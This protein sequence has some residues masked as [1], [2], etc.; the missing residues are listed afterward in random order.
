MDN[1]LPGT[2]SYD[3]L[4][5]RWNGNL[6]QVHSLI[7]LIE[8]MLKDK[9]VYY[10]LDF[11]TFPS[12]VVPQQ[13]L[14][15]EQQDRIRYDE[16][17]ARH[18][19]LVQE[20]A[21][22]E[23]N[24]GAEFRRLRQIRDVEHQ[25]LSRHNEE[26]FWWMKDRRPKE[27]KF[28]LPRTLCE[29]HHKKEISEYPKDVKK[30]LDDC[31]SIIKIYE[32]VLS[33]TIFNDYRIKLWA[34]RLCTD[35]DRQ[36]AV[37]PLLHLMDIRATPNTNVLKEI[38]ADFVNISSI[39]NFKSALAACAILTKVQEELSHIDVA[40]M[41]SDD[42]L[43][44]C[45]VKQ[46]NQRDMGLQ[47][48]MIKYSLG[49]GILAPASVQVT[50]YT[51]RAAANAARAANPIA[52]VSMT[53]ANF[54]ANLESMDKLINVT[55]DTSIYAARGVAF[56][57]SLAQSREDDREMRKREVREVLREQHDERVNTNREFRHR[58]RSQERQRSQSHDR[59]RDRSRSRDRNAG[60]TPAPQPRPYPNWDNKATVPASTVPTH[61]RKKFEFNHRVNVATR[62]PG[63]IL[64]EVKMDLYGNPFIVPDPTSGYVQYLQPDDE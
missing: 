11:D 20:N 5:E 59:P 19:T 40:L 29:S 52:I 46:F 24:H 43:I 50:S 53:W 37:S 4:K 41:K 42:F 7:P 25:P 38:E 33:P 55:Q 58:D 14:H 49:E 13:A 54:I 3:F 60:H 56:S 6:R 12:P 9:A 16:A 2:Q 21:F 15:L 23:Q 35:S 27:A 10:M 22:W 39:G 1:A 34:N 28:K 47:Q 61:R 32:Q 57:T 36:K 44:Q 31:N 26:F 64:S 62:E 48:F 51:A 45:I 63:Q 30:E 18:E 8:S 17:V